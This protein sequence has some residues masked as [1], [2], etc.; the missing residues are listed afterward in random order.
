MINFRLQLLFAIFIAL[1]VGM[2]LLGGKLVSLFG[3]AVSVGIFMVPITFLITDIVAEVYGKKVVRNFIISG[4]VVF[5]FIFLYTSVFVYLEPHT[6]FSFNEEYKTIFGSSLRMIV[7]SIVAFVLSQSHDLF[8]F[9][10]IKK[11]TGGKFL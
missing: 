4:V 9:E 2:N 10:L 11:K 8:T 5:I 3:V 6:R 1:L 7:A